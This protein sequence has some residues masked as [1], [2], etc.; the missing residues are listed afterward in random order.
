M[1]NVIIGFPD[2]QILSENI[3]NGVNIEEYDFRGTIIGE[4]GLIRSGSVIY[5]G[6]E[7]GDHFKTGHNIV[8]REDTKIGNNV[9]I[10]TGTVIDGSTTIGSN[11]SIQ[12]NVYIPR[13]TTIMENVFIGP[14]AVLTNDKYPVRKEYE[15]RGPIIRKGAS[16]GANST[17]L[18]DVEIG[19][20]AMVAAGA[21]VT[22]DVPRWSL[23]IGSPAKIVELPKELKTQNKI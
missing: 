15:L 7:I 23:A 18:P 17:T 1:E 22:K 10:G 9:L 13:N 19:E 20:G 6:T 2:A 5:C 16:I 3:K 12:S 14:N 21:L 11:V 8:I 4:G